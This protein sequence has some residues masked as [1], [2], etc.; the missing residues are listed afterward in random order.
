MRHLRARVALYA[1]LVAVCQ[2]G[3]VV[4]ASAVMLT[5]PH[6]D[7]A[8]LEDECSC[9]H[10]AAV[11]CP[12]HRRSTPRPVPPGTPRWCGAGDDSLFALV[13]VLGALTAPEAVHAL[14][15][16]PRLTL[17]TP[18]FAGRLVRPD[19]PPDSPPPRA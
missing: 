6:S 14:L 7:K 13:P 2:G 19:R 11:M 8:V 10:S 1:L 17:A 4:S 3:M 5:T 16:P 18:P 15:P 12:M 9:E